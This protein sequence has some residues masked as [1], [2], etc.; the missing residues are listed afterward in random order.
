MFGIGFLELLV[1][2]ILAVIL[3]GPERLPDILR[4]IATFYREL[5]RMGTDV[6][7]TFEVAM[8]EDEEI[9]RSVK[10]ESLRETKEPHP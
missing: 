10:A 1:I 5:K 4:R 6:R 9:K 2:V 8:S 3:L 7:E